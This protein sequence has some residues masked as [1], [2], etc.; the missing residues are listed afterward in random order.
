MGYQLIISVVFITNNLGRWA[1]ILQMCEKH[2]LVAIRVPAFDGGTFRA[3]DGKSEQFKICD[4]DVTS[5]WDS[6]LNSTF[7]KK[8]VSNVAVP[9]SLSEKA[10]AMSHINVWRTIASSFK[11]SFVDGSSLA[12]LMSLYKLSGS[13]FTSLPTEKDSADN[14][15]EEEWYLIFEDDAVLRGDLEEPFCEKV[16]QLTKSLTSRVDILFLGCVIPKNASRIKRGKFIQP[17]YLWQ[18]HAYCITKRTAKILLSFL[19]VDCPVDNFIA[20]LVHDSIITVSCFIF[21]VSHICTLRF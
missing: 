10:C 15:S 3:S 16:R 13:L 11:T 12:E 18:L 1:R 2:E 5:T 7:D 6:T 4:E 20:R 21:F 8:C 9:M 14:S 17:N 19:P